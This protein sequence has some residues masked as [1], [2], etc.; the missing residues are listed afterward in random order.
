MADFL[1]TLIEALPFIARITGG[2][3]TVT[4]RDGVRIR[5]YDSEGQEIVE[6]R[7]TVFE[8][9]REV[10]QNGQVRI[11]PS[12]IIADAEAWALPLGEYVIAS[13][14]LERVMREKELLESLKSALPFIARVAG[15]EAVLFDEEGKRTASVGYDGQPNTNFIGRVSKAAQKAMKTGRPVIGESMS[16]TAES[17]NSWTTATSIK[18]CSP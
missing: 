14:N 9:A 6:W 8:L 3:A 12:Q 10:G 1:E 5:T 2:Y 15:G 16:A 4:D 7:G 13:S 17:S 18:P 11:G